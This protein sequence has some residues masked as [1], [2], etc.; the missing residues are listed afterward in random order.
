[1]TVFTNLVLH[2]I[3]LCRIEILSIKFLFINR[4]ELNV[5]NWIS[6]SSNFFQRKLHQQFQKIDNWI[7]M[8]YQKKP[9]NPF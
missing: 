8:F 1:M 6:I 7:S 5:K 4:L 3:R 2:E 9:Q